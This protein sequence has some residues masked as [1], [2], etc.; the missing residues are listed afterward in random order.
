M[1]A[2]AEIEFIDVPN[3]AKLQHIVSLTLP[4]II[5]FVTLRFVV[6]CI[7]SLFVHTASRLSPS[8]VKMLVFWARVERS[9]SLAGMAATS[10]SLVLASAVGGTSVMEETRLCKMASSPRPHAL[11]LTAALIGLIST[12]NLKSNVASTASIVLFARRSPLTWMACTLSLIEWASPV[13]FRRELIAAFAHVL[14]FLV[15]LMHLSTCG[16]NHVSTDS[17]LGSLSYVGATMWFFTIVY[18]TIR[19]KRWKTE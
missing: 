5:G 14:V 17:V 7:V 12:T 1:K 6:L 13:G 11:F 4:V 8:F 16:K 19:E 15:T 2:V 10:L 18:R 9:A 3:L